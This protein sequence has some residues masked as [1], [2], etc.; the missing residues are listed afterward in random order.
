MAIAFV[1]NKLTTVAI[2]TSTLYIQN[3]ALNIS[4]K[5]AGLSS[6]FRKDIPYDKFRNNRVMD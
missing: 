6:G 4:G 5:R 2:V 1:V 3:Q